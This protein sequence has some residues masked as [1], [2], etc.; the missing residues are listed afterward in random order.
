MNTRP[1]GKFLITAAVCL[2]VLSCAFPAEAIIFPHILKEIPL[3]D[4][5]DDGESLDEESLKDY[6]VKRGDTLWDIAREHG[7]PWWELAKLND[8]REGQFIFDGQELK[9]PVDE[10]ETYLVQS[11]DCLWTIAR[12]HGVSTNSLARENSIGNPRRLRVGSRLRI[13]RGEIA[14]VSTRA[15]GEGIWRRPLEGPVTSRFGPRGSEFHHGLDIASDAGSPIYPISE[16]RVTFSGWLNN[17][18]GR[19]V[20]IDHGGNIESLYAHS[21]ENIVS[22][23]DYVDHSTPI[24]KVG[25]TGRSTGPHVHLEIHVGGKPVDP[26]I[27]VD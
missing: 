18:Y 17:I 13:P 20:I 1:I 11:G 12:K 21:M 23:G 22:A 8:I 6:I 27:Y 5:L 9:I 3:E 26:Q 10:G 24:A 15:P 4:L 2:A 16:G 14:A 7:V 25:S 19:A